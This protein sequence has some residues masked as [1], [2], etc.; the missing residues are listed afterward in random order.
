MLKIAEKVKALFDR[1]TKTETKTGAPSPRQ[2]RR[3]YA[4]YVAR[5]QRKG[6]RAYVRAE[7][8]KEFKRDTLLSQQR[9]LA[10]AGTPAMQRN[11]RNAVEHTQRRQ[12]RA[13]AKVRAA[14]AKAALS[15]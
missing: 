1:A 15:A 14:K 3:A 4:R 10:G 11:V 12:E 2:Q 7:L 5:Q 13:L 9:V 8:K 6:R